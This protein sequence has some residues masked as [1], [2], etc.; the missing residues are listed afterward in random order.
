M[1]PSFDVQSVPGYSNHFSP[2]W[3]E[4]FPKF[5]GDPSLGIS[6]VME[7]MKYAS[8]LNVRH[9]DVLI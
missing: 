6:H 1:Y 9:E 4:S 7:Y 3:R 5:D 2:D 8:R